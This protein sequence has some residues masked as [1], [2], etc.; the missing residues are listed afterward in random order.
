MD[1]KNNIPIGN[2]NTNHLVTLRDFWEEPICIFTNIKSTTP[3]QIKLK[4][5]LINCKEPNNLFF[6]V[7]AIIVMKYR[8]TNDKSIKMS[9][10]AF[11]PGAILNTRQKT[12]TNRI[13]K[14]TGWMQFDID[15]KDNPH[16]TDASMLRDQVKNISY[17]AFCSLS[18][19]GKGVWGLVIVSDI[20][21]YKNHFEQLKHDFTS[22][23]I[24][25]DPS[26]GGNPT[27]LRIYSYDP[28][29]YFAD[30][31]KIYDRI[32]SPPKKVKR[33]FKGSNGLNEK[34]KMEQY[35]NEINL[36][37]LDIAPDYESYLKLGFALANEYKEGGRKYFQAI[38]SQSSKYNENNTDTQFTNCLKA[39]GE[40]ISIATFY[41]LCK[42]AGLII[43]NNGKS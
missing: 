23:N 11:C 13:D 27:D 21:K 25:L 4:Q 37:Q 2:S 39:K 42:Q 33:T 5:W 38:C 19:S 12:A 41:Y 29:A 9:L 34:D 35:I 7:Q 28:H 17:V 3:N 20:S 16:I 31:F 6:C 24:Y 18:A 40:G 10:P 8:E 32:Y 36:R 14:L 1:K 22:R 26:K 43:K 30:K 15:L